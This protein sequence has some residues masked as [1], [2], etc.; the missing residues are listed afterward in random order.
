MKRQQGEQSDHLA[1]ISPKRLYPLSLLQRQSGLDSEEIRLALRRGLVSHKAGDRV[2][3]LGSDFIHWVVNQKSDEKPGQIVEPVSPTRPSYA[4]KELLTR[5]EAA[6][7]LSLKPQ[8]LGNWAI[9]GKGPR[10]VRLGRAVRYRLQDLEEFIAA[11][12]R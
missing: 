10:A 12:G 1:P 11:G 4:G 8:T 2:F 6:E 3:V 7:F 9:T 5:T